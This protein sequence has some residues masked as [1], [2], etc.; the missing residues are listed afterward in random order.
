MLQTKVGRVVIVTT[1]AQAGGS[2]GQLALID[3]NQFTV[4]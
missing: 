3:Y 1:V 4:D 2:S